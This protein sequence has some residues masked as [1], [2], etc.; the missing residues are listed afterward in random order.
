MI[1]DNSTLG[2]NAVV[3]GASTGIGREVVKL[4][5][6]HTEVS[7]V[8]AIARSASK[9]AELK[10]FDCDGKLITVAFD[11]VK[12]D[13]SLIKEALAHIGSIGVLINNAGMLVNKSFDSITQ[14]DLQEVYQ[15]NVFAPFLLTQTLMPWL[16]NYHGQAHVV[17]VGSV[18]GVQGSVKFPGLSAYSSSKGALSVLSECLAAE[19]NSTNIS[20]NCLALGAV[21]TEMLAAAFPKF[22]TK[23][24]PNAMAEYIVRFALND[25]MLL[26]G[27]VL[28][29]SSSTP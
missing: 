23:T 26:N 15:V 1:T 14:S 18:G 10:A 8:V 19:L 7:K 5:L 3:T 27:K 13:H 29:V 6:A 12:T 9:L 11:L 25:S 16:R 20:V 22:R 4:L 28:C 2:V 17:N 21:Q 24:T